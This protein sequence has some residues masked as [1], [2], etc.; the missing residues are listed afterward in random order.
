MHLSVSFL[1]M[2]KASQNCHA[3]N[4]SCCLAVSVPSF[5][6]VL[7]IQIFHPPCLLGGGTAL[8]LISVAPQASL[9]HPGTETQSCS[10]NRGPAL[11]STPF[12]LLPT[13]TGFLFACRWLLF[14]P[15]ISGPLWCGFLGCAVLVP[16]YS[17]P[18]T[19]GFN[20]NSDVQR[21]DMCSTWGMWTSRHLH[22]QLPFNW[23]CFCAPRL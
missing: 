5:S 3:I 1:K 14:I 22:V 23:P 16:A 17:S 12:L 2:S 18:V 15:C 11:F 10:H 9:Q 13:S 21:I 4:A 7:S 6:H 19:P 8:E 20:S